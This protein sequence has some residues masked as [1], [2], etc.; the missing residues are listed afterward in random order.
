[1][2]TGLIIEAGTVHALELRG[3]SA[4]LA[5]RCAKALKDAELGDSIAVNGVCLTVT[6]IRSDV[7]TFD[8]SYETLKSTNLGALKR[9]EYVNLEPSLR[10]NSKLGGHLVSG[11]VEA[12]GSIRSITPMGNAVKFEVVA[13]ASL[14]QYLIP[15]GSVAVDGISLTVVDVLD[16]AFTLVIIPHTGD[17]T[18][19]RNKKPGDNVNL[20]SDLIAK[21]VAKF[22]LQGKGKEQHDPGKNDASLLDALKRSGFVG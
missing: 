4:S 19:I 10:L 20:E 12:V 15:K 3:P 13:P 8:V 17:I 6:A 14:L 11:H 22:A 21:Y 16:D 5:V 9:G 1:M 18:T 2:F 7:L